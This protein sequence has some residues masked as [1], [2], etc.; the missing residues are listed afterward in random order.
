MSSGSLP[1][2]LLSLS[3]GRIPSM[4]YDRVRDTVDCDLKVLSLHVYSLGGPC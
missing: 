3:N 1:S 4:F 2:D